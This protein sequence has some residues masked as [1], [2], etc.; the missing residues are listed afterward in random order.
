MVRGPRCV[1]GIRRGTGDPYQM[2]LL[3]DAKKMTDE[4]A[5]SQQ[6]TSQSVSKARRRRIGEPF[7]DPERATDR[8]WILWYS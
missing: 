8:W 4:K 7:A 6:S 5:N 3:S 1:P 2:M